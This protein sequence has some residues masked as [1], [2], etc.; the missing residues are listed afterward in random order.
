MK[1]PAERSP[2]VFIV[3]D[4]AAVREGLRSLLR[5]VDLRV[6]TFGAASEFLQSGLPGALGCLVLDVRLP[7]H[8]QFPPGSNNDIQLKVR[9]VL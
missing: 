3:D 4:D 1:K 6:E 2:V 9:D 7:P 8:R 5:S